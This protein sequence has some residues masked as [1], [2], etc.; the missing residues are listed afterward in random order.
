M[1]GPEGERPTVGLLN[2]TKP[3]QRMG[4][5]PRYDWTV[6]WRGRT[7]ERHPV[8][9]KRE[10]GGGW[11]KLEREGKNGRRCRAVGK[12]KLFLHSK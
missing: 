5:H 12:L 10:K 2:E 4:I 1:V 9:R 7:E 11:R 8:E 3:L 6:G